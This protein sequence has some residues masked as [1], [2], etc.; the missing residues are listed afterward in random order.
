MELLLLNLDQNPPEP[1]QELLVL[2]MKTLISDEL[3]KHTDE[4]VKISV[5]ACLTEIARITAP[6]DP[7]DDEKMKVLVLIWCNCHFSRIIDDECKLL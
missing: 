2:P 1:I 3:L 5:T 7:Y 6:N 4:D